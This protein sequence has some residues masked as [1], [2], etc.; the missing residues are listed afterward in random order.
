ME[1]KVFWVRKADKGP[2]ETLILMGDWCSKLTDTKNQK[3]LRYR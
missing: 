1:P 3:K 2:T